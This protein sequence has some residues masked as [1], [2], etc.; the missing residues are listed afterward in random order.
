MNF[1]IL[2]Y[3][4]KGISGVTPYL[5]RELVKNLVDKIKCLF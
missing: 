3:F 5:N 2:C 1:D 4:V